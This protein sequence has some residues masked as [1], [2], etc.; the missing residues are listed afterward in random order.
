MIFSSRLLCARLDAMRVLLA[1]TYIGLF[2]GLA[3]PTK[4]VESKNDKP[5]DNIDHML[6]A[7]ELAAAH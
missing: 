4:A 1:C 2:P 7:F 3:V 5:R 6:H